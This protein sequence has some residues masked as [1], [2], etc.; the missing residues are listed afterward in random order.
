M[1]FSA[2]AIGSTENSLPRCMLEKEGNQVT[3]SGRGQ[4]NEHSTGCGLKQE[5]CLPV[6]QHLDNFAN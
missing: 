5:R 1:E 4:R 3:N 6:N 2:S